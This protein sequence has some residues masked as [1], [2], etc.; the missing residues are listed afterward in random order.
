MSEEADG[1]HE[2][3]IQPNGVGDGDDDGGADRQRQEE[4][5]SFEVPGA[6]IWILT[7]CAGVSGLL[8]GYE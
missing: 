1:A 3:L 6:F 2:P 7:F 5:R 4:E 8:F